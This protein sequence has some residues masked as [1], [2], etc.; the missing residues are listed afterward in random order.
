MTTISSNRSFFTKVEET[1]R[2]I[3]RVED[4]PGW[5]R[6]QD[7]LK[8][9]IRD[10]DMVL[11]L[12]GGANPMV[13]RDPARNIESVLVDL[14]SDELL[15][16]SGSYSEVICA[17]ATMPTDAFVE[18]VGANRYDLI[19]SHMFIEHIKDPDQMHRNCMA[20]LKPGGRVIH[21]YPI[22]NTFALFVNSLVPESVS[23]AMVRF[24]H[25]DRDLDGNLG[26]F[27][28][29]YRRCHSPSKRATRYFQLFGFEVEAHRAFS[30]HG[31]Y[32]RIPV[33]RS[34]ELLLRRVAVRWQL[35]LVCFG[36]VVLRKPA[37][38]A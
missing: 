37:A 26:K 9:Y 13:S 8:G 23:R 12:G 33:V 25:P 19:V 21:A 35:P 4:F 18:I 28:A 14:S 1:E 7:F 36:L 27:P 15:K 2:P 6:Y 29:Y 16:A 17:D 38:K 3:G 20:V 32:K 10:G 24:T 31:Y 5:I 30:G 34:V 22:N 11:D